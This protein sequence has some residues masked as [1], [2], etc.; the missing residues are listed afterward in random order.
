M[1]FTFSLLFIHALICIS[2]QQPIMI[3][4]SHQNMRVTDIVPDKYLYCTQYYTYHCYGEYP[5]HI[6]SAAADDFLFTYIDGECSSGR[7][8]QA[9]LEFLSTMQ[10]LVDTFNNSLTELPPYMLGDSVFTTDNTKRDY[11]TTFVIDTVS[12]WGHLDTTYFTNQY[13]WVDSSF[14]K[15]LNISWWTY[16]C[17]GPYS[18]WIE[19]GDTDLYVV[20]RKIL[21]ADTLYGWVEVRT[22]FGQLIFKSFAISGDTGNFIYNAIKPIENKEPEVKLYPNPTNEKLFI[23]SPLDNCVV[24]IFSLEGRKQLHIEINS[25]AE[26]IDISNLSN[27]LYFVNIS[28]DKSITRK[29]VKE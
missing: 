29:F 12:P 21:P 2:A 8:Y 13:A 1:R 11:T 25:K 7:M 20:F 18:G 6:D 17:T 23:E 26:S 19:Q 10:I 14:K 22:S 16:N 9:Q 27:G 24:E 28:S 4:G 5:L 15:Y 3:T